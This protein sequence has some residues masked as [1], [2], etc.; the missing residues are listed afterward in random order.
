MQRIYWLISNALINNCVM[1]L[2]YLE[3]A[4]PERGSYIIHGIFIEER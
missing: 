2:P 1:P 3:K 4:G